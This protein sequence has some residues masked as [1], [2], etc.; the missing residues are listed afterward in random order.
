MGRGVSIRFNRFSVACLFFL[1][2]VG[3]FFFLLNNS[4][5]WF[6]RCHGCR[7]RQSPERD[8]LVY[9]FIFKTS[10][11]SNFINS[12]SFLNKTKQKHTDRTSFPPGW[13]HLP[14]FPQRCSEEPPQG[15]AYIT[16]S[17]LSNFSELAGLAAVGTTGAWAGLGRRAS[18]IRLPFLTG[19]LVLDSKVTKNQRCYV[20]LRACGVWPALAA[21]LGET[22]GVSDGFVGI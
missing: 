13:T 14:G 9:L 8:R 3:W 2:F 10:L 5:K 6:D 7:S 17:F 12:V 15:S 21:L 18:S 22:G 4:Y 1:T 20:F 11:F 19:Q 16:Q